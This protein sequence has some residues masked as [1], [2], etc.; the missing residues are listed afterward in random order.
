[1]KTHGKFWLLFCLVILIAVFVLFSFYK[2]TFIQNL[3]FSDAAKSADIAR[4]LLSGLGY[5]GT[6]SF[7][8]S[9]IG[10]LSQ[11]EAF[12]SPWLPPLT[13]FSIALFFRLFGISDLAVIAPSFMYFIC[14]V[15]FI[16]LLG[17]KLFGNLVGVLS[18]VVVATSKDFL[19]YA[20][21]GAT[22]PLFTLEIVAVT[23]F[24]S[25]KK[26]WATIFATVFMV[27]MY[28][29]RPQAFIYI[30]GLILYWLLLKYKIKK[31]IL[32]FGIILVAG[33]FVDYLVLPNFAGK[34]FLYSITSRGIGTATAVVAGGS[35]SD[36]LRGT[37]V[38]VNTGGI[39]T[40]VKKVFYN[41]YNF[42]KL[43]PQIM[44]PYLFAL[45]VIGLF[46][47]NK[48]RVL[49]SYKIASIFMF[50]LTLLVAAASIPFFRYVHPV[51]PLIYIIAVGTLLEIV[52]FKITNHKS[53]ILVATFL[54]LIFAVGQSL[55]VIFLD[56][57]FTRNTHNIGKP[58]VYVSLSYILRDNTEHDNVVVTN[59]DTWGSWYGQRKTIWFPVEPKQLIDP[60]TGKIPFDAIYL[61]SYLIDDQNYYMGDSWRIIFK[62]S[63]DSKKW[64][65][66]GCSE[67]TKEFKFKGKY[68]IPASD[69][70]EN[71]DV[72]AILLVRKK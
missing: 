33:F 23:Y 47:R 8:S 60:T 70:Y 72:N 32:I 44:N 65:C 28:F 10:G 63:E 3:S 16:F 11:N 40:V 25:L 71:Q 43:L 6:F 69:N 24:I 46:V 15:V 66:D 64:T 30:A 45:F 55:G 48:N 27:L 13:P 39:L 56:S 2:F 51:V 9:G 19:N 62:N 34:Y 29:T 57:R 54:I 68:T 17:R 67:I 38:S 21:Q 50:A 52:S 12:P 7:W 4:N 49:Y 53:I 61:T 36:S 1:M 31:A 35:A 18:A 14:L 37:V 58:P 20:T 26:K 41:L 42:Y 5:K 59:L 22:E